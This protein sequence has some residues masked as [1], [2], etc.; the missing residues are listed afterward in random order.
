MFILI[1]DDEK[2]IR[3]SLQSMLEELYPDEHIYIHASD[4][5]AAIW[6]V[7]KISPDVAFL[8]IRMPLINGLEALEICRTVSPSTKWIIL[9]GYADFEY[10]QKALNLSA[11]SYLLKPVDLSTLKNLI[12]G[13]K[14]QKR[15]ETVQ[16]N[17]LFTLDIIRTFH[18]SDMLGT[19]EASFLPYEK[20]KYVIYQIYM[21]NQEKERQRFVKH[22]IYKKL[23]EFCSASNTVSY[24]AIFFN[25]GGELCILCA[26]QDTSHLT[27]FIN[28]RLR[29][30]SEDM[31]SV[32]CGTASSVE[33]AYQISRRIEDVAEIR[34]VY[35]C[36]TAQDI[37]QINALKDLEELLYFSSMINTAVRNTLIGNLETVRQFAVSSGQDARLSG[38][39][40]K[41]DHEI[42]YQYLGKILQRPFHAESFSEFLREISAAAEHFSVERP[43]CGF[44]ITQIKNFVHQ[45]YSKD[46][47]IS[48]V[49]EF[50]NISPTYFSK[51]FHE[52]TGQKYI[53]FVTEVRI[54]N[55][56]K[57]IRAYPDLSVRQVAEAVG[58]TSVRHFSKTF[59][60]YTGVLPSSY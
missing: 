27:Y 5:R 50:F 48:T 51:L 57:L 55:A 52:K 45:N 8:D 16:N 18:M 36:R 35:N 9:S 33:E 1:A 10:A 14:E 44:D 46:V 58:Y 60:K 17:K 31:I 4:G 38:I 6:Q 25:A 24:H 40:S 47:S 15:Q 59:Q 28:S 30:Y 56:K 49:S 29:E 43:E 7:Q 12:D 22:A 3:L 23:E 19:N 53:D 11:Y 54:E 37:G 20:G 41:F 42:L 26:V 21:D 2:M 13:I 34:F 32:F 39:F